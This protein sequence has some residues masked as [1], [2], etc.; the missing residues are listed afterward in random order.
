[1][2]YLLDTRVFLWMQAQ[3]H[4]LG[5]QTLSILRAEHHN[6]HLSAASAWEIAHKF[7]D[8][9]LALPEPPDQ[10]ILDRMATS[11]VTGLAIEPSH[12]LGVA[13]VDGHDRDLIDRLLIAQAAVEDMTLIT[14]DA[15]LPNAAIT[16][17]D[18][19]M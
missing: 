13:G 12:A 10:Y 8:G 4:M 15:N 9:Q 16:T 14:A 19:T 17:I 2:N 11:G 5:A 7:R 18:A 6:L 3:P 1:V